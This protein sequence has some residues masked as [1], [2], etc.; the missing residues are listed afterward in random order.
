[1]EANPD[2]I[3]LEILY[4]WKKYGINRLSLGVQSF[5][6]T[7]LIWMNRA[8]RAADSLQSIND[9]LTA[10][11]NNFSVDL[12]YGSPFLSDDELVKNLDIIFEKQIPHIS[13]YALTVE[14]K[15]ALSKMISDRKELTILPEKQAS[16][17]L[18]LMDWMKA[19]QFEHYEISNFAKSGFR[20]RHNSSYWNR[21]SYYGFGPSAHSFDGMN[22]RRWNVAN[23]SVYIQS[24]QKD[25]IP[26]EEEILS[27]MQQ[28]NET[29][30]ITLRT[31]EGIDLDFIAEQFG[32]AYVP[33]ITAQSKKYIDSGKLLRIENRLVLTNEGK[34]FA[35][36]IAADLFV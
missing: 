20:S 24:L 2:D 8:H 31:M 22:K 19:H 12:I 23:N 26:F 13:C 21:R 5:K 25:I 15:T 17:F 3:N 16:Q 10:G 1:M 18:L 32:K 30:M 6:E 29:I 14:P 36:G 34:L 27:D 35:D 9:I 33:S 28:L 7:E 11:F 4:A